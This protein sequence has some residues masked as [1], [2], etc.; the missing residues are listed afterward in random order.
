MVHRLPLLPFTPFFPALP[1]SQNK[2]SPTLSAFPLP[3]SSSLVLGSLSPPLFSQF[4]G[5]DPPCPCLAF[6]PLSSLSHLTWVLLSH[7]L[8]LPARTPPPPTHP[9]GMPAF[10]FLFRASFAH[11]DLY[12][13]LRFFCTV[14]LPFWLHT[15]IIY[16]FDFFSSML[17]LFSLPA[18]AFSP[19]SSASLSFLSPMRCWFLPTT[20]LP[21][22]ALALSQHYFTY[23]ILPSLCVLSSLFLLFAFHHIYFPCRFLGSSGCVYGR[24]K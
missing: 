17:C 10:P 7:S 9:H 12:M 11:W 3:R 5:W 2:T 14:F 21:A 18:G 16:E 24:S 1:P 6:L 23:S 8:S 20:P 13:L 22:A 15:P 4:W 19:P